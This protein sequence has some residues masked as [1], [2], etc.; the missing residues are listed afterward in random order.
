MVFLTHCQQEIYF[1]LLYF[2]TDEEIA[3]NYQSEVSHWA[4][5]DKHHALLDCCLYG[6][7]DFLNETSATI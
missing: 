5:V 2:S 1:E 3:G 6:V 4:L 7:V